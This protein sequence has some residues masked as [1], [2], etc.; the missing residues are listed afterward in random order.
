MKLFKNAS[1]SVLMAVIL[2]FTPISLPVIQTT[3][4]AHAAAVKLNKSKATLNIGETLNLTLTSTK[5]AIK[6]STSSQKTA[7]VST[8]G[9]VTALKKGTATITATVG[10][11]KYKCV[12]TVKEPRITASETNIISNSVAAITITVKN[13]KADEYLMHSSSN[14][15]IA[16][17]TISEWT[18]DKVTLYIETGKKGKATINVHTNRDKEPVV[19]NV[20]VADDARTSDKSL[21]PT[22][23]YDKCASSVV[24]INTDSG[25]GTGFFISEGVIA[26]NY[27]VIEGATELS[28]VHD[29]NTYKVNQIL[30]YDKNLDIAIL[31]VSFKAKPLTLSRFAPKT[32]NT[33]YAIGSSQGLEGTLSNGL[34][35]ASSR[36]IEDV[37]YIQ[38]NAAISSGN[39]GGPLLNSY[40]EVVG[41]NTMQLVDGQNLNFAINIYQLYQVDRSKPITADEFCAKNKE[42]IEQNTITEDVLKSGS[43][44][45]AQEVKSGNYINGSL[46]SNQDVDFYK[47]TLTKVTTVTFTAANATNSSS[48]LLQLNMGLFDQNDIQLST[49]RYY[50]GAVYTTAVLQPGT[51]YAEMYNTTQNITTSVPYI[52]LITY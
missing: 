28:V 7:K 13:K 44:Y 48:D 21:T 33:V 46:T 2:I 37:D 36:I 39:S 26:T 12:V 27:H 30:G 52:A 19:L 40:G 34:V 50:N 17:C 6:W 35:T 11:S 49:A 31:S 42:E 4:I 15:N 22:N 5:S 1:I 51:Y 9:V 32:G 10:K 29:E 24:Q 43:L 8:K 14:K 20:Q 23:L 3:T 38:T 41:I 25:L 18:G 45:T 16:D 47:F